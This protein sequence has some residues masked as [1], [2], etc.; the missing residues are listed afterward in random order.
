MKIANESARKVIST[1][2]V[3]AAFLFFTGVAVFSSAQTFTSLASFDDN[4]GVGPNGPLIQAFDGDLYGTTTWSGANAY[5][6]VFKVAQSGTVTTLYNFCS[7]LGC[8]DGWS[9][10]AGL[11]QGA[12]G[13]L[14]GTTSLR[15]GPQ[16]G[17]GSVFRITTSGTL[18]TLHD[19][20]ESDGKWP[21][22]VLFQANDGNLY[23]TTVR[24]GAHT[25]GTAFKISTGGVF[26]SLYSFCS[27]ANCGDGERPAGPL[28]QASDG[29]FY[30]ATQDGGSGPC[31]CGTVFRMTPTGVLTT[32]HSFNTVDGMRPAGGL[33][34]TVQGDLYGTTS[35]G[36]PNKSGTIFKLAPNGTLTTLHIFSGTD[37]SYPSG[38]L[39]QGTDG[40]FYGTTQVGGAFSAGTVFQITPTGTLTTLYSFCS[41]SN[42]EDGELPVGGIMQDTSGT[43]Y[44]TSQT[45]GL[46]G[47]GTVF[48][49]TLGLAPFVKTNPTSGKVGWK[50][51]VFGS[52]LRGVTGVSFNGTPATFSVLS[53][54]KLI[55]TVPNGASTGTVGVTT[56][57]GMLAS[58]VPFR[59]IP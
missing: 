47:G 44:G 55:A 12:D 57:S 41:Q 28:V 5:G 40:N 50:I 33:T 7:E 9:P 30:G 25:Q 31:T 51:T 26:T 22:G 34:P 46:Y 27:Q 16:P 6:T 1:I 52:N 3:F 58:N 21:M 13:N 59:V 29:N 15:A 19:F 18:T 17:Y 48:S 54:T 23:G 56:A 37:G 24:G 35:G 4:D 45:G 11:I 43:F 42:C 32:L 53:D 36:G 8:T 20:Q 39:V 38:S 10:R 49:L 14:Y 2:K